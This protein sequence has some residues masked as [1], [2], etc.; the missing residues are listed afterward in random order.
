MGSTGNRWAWILLITAR[1]Q[2]SYKSYAMWYELNQLMQIVS[3]ASF[4]QTMENSDP[5]P[6]RWTC[7]WKLV[8]VVFPFCLQ[9]VNNGVFLCALKITIHNKPWHGNGV[10][11]SGS[12]WGECT[13]H[14]WIPLK[15][16]RNVERK[17]LFL[18]ASPLFW[19]NSAA[20]YLKRLSGQVV[21]FMWNWYDLYIGAY[22]WFV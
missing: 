16:S 1:Y 22:R 2:A 21:M 5:P 6:A 19:T 13:G 17:L 7:S 18:L 14:R 8:N 15:R 20:G 9:T 10:R 11:I 4:H 12:L 3:S